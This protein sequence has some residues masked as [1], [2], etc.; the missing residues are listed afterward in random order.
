MPIRLVWATSAVVA[1]MGNR[2]RIR[3]VIRSMS[4][5]IA[6]LKALTPEQVQAHL[7]VGRLNA[8]GTHQ[9]KKAYRRKTKYGKR[10]W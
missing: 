6:D 4:T 8:R 7:Q 10:D 9:S 1:I 3:R 2:A 5:R